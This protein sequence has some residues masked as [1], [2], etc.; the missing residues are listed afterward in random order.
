M[1]WDPEAGFGLQPAAKQCQRHRK[2]QTGTSELA[3]SQPLYVRTVNY[4]GR[5]F[6]KWDYL[7]NG[8]PEQMLHLEAHGDDQLQ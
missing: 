3:T 4:K 7:L 1:S 2:V 6:E 5:E 8:E